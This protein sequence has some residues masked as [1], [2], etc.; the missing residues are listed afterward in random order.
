VA[1]RPDSTERTKTFATALKE[2]GVAVT[3][4]PGEGKNHGTINSELGNEGD[5]PTIAV[6]EFLVK[7]MKGNP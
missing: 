2:A 5:K 7:I 6:F 3:V 4:V 1:D